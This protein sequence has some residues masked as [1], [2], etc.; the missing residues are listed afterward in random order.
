MD[1]QASDDTL[2]QGELTGRRSVLK[3]LGPAR[4]A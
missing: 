1:R 4:W 2:R 3:G